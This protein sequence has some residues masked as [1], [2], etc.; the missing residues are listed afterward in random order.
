[1]ADRPAETALPLAGADTAIAPPPAS[2]AQ[3][4][5]ALGARSVC[6]YLALVIGLVPLWPGSEALGAPLVLFA[7]VASWRELRGVPRSVLLMV[8]AAALAALVWAP[9]MLADAAAAAARLTSLVIAVMLLSA[10]LGRSRGLD[11]LSASLMTGRPLPRYL[12]LTCATGFL[13]LPLNFGSVGVMS[14]MV[15]RVMQRSGNTA[16]T[17]NA[18]RGVLRGFGLASLGSPLS[19]SLA[20]TLTL[21]PGLTVHGVLSVSLPFA[22]FFLLLGAVFR[23]PEPAAAAGA[24]LAPDAGSAWRAWLRF[25]AYI[26]A[27]CAAAFTLYGLGGMTYARAVAIACVGAV[28]ASLLTA[29]RRGDPASP[30]PMGR[31]GNELAVMSGSAFLGVIV[32]SAGLAALGSEFTLPAAAWPFAAFC[33]PWLM[34]AGGMLGLNP[35]VSG[36]LAGAMLG[37]IA[38]ASAITGIGFAMLAGWGL[39]V[40]GT[41]YSANSM[42]LSRVTGYDAHVAAFHWNLKLSLTT[43]SAAGLLAA[44]L[45]QW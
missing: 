20:I 25:G 30:P 1:M 41:P 7:V 44:L 32:S 40:S 22:L 4:D 5:S 36:T 45:T 3:P 38:P 6:I 26:A 33:V 17:R 27:I 19:I 34:F 39:T 16:L 14:A 10:T 43:L 29:R 42:L 21:L 2:T 37:P 8:L 31:T 35:I 13:A 23:E 28:I 12:G 15:A 24:T 18:A 9:Q 11:D